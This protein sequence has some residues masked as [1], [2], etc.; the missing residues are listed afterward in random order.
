MTAKLPVRIGHGFDLHRLDAL[1]PAGEGRPFILGGVAFEHDRGPVA[2][3]DGDVLLHAIV[4]A[5][6]GAIGGPDIGGLFP[7]DDPQYDGADSAGFVSEAVRRV[8]AAGY[9]VGN[10]DATVICERPKL[11]PK[12]EAV[13]AAVAR[14]LGVPVEQV[15]VKATTHERVDAIGEGRAIAVHAVVVLIAA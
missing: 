8:A 3:S 11:G 1:A 12:R 10:L 13:R 2:H 4:D 5:L 14:L 9:A 7:D 15:N 6:M